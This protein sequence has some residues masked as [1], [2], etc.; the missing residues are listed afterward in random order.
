MVYFIWVSVI[1]A[2]GYYLYYIW[3]EVRNVALVTELVVGSGQP[4]FVA[5]LHH[6][7][8]D[9]EHD[10]ELNSFEK[11]ISFSVV[12]QLDVDLSD[13]GVDEVVNLW[14]N[15][16][17]HVPLSDQTLDAVVG[18]NLEPFFCIFGWSQI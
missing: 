8:F 9:V 7:D 17:H 18:S 16:Q 4:Q 3:L 2:E 13:I 1:F 10:Q 11:Y 12:E 15:I 14:K 6:F 5:V